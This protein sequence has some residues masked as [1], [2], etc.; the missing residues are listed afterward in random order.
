MAG[1]VTAYCAANLMK[2]SYALNGARHAMGNS[3]HIEYKYQRKAP[4][5]P[6]RVVDDEHRS[7]APDR[8]SYASDLFPALEQ[9]VVKRLQI[10]ERHAQTYDPAACSAGPIVF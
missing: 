4:N 2:H 10:I 3:H 8:V 9:I 7:C 6:S 5:P 1:R